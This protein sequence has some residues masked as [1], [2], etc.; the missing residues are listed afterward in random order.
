MLC[1]QSWYTQRA[2]LIICNYR[3]R[4]NNVEDQ[5]KEFR[6]RRPI[7]QEA[8]FVVCEA[9]WEPFAILVDSRFLGESGS[10]S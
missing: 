2:A 5:G 7:R 4:E 3:A 8:L 6:R 9:G 10:A 1:I